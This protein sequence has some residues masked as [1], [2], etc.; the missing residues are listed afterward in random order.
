MSDVPK[1]GTLAWPGEWFC[2]EEAG[3]IGWAK[4]Q[5]SLL[6]SLIL[7]KSLNGFEQGSDISKA[8]ILKG[9]SG[10]CLEILAF[11]GGRGKIKV[12]RGQETSLET[13]VILQ[14]QQRKKREDKENDHSMLKWSFVPNSQWF[15]SN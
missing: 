3:E 7:I 5:K 4:L 12:F 11:F 13:A 15:S 2:K 8:L 14:W 6:K 9:R 10:Y 1:S